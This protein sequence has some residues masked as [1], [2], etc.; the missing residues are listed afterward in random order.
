MRDQTQVAD[1]STTP[2]AVEHGRLSEFERRVLVCC[3]TGFTDVKLFEAQME[4][5]LR[6]KE[7]DKTN[8][9][10]LTTLDKPEDTNLILNWCKK[11]EYQYAVWLPNWK[12]VDVEGA[13]VK[14]NSYGAYNAL[15]KVWRDRDIAEAANEGI[16]FYD[17][18]SPN[19][20]DMNERMNDLKNSL[21]IVLVHIDEKEGS[22]NGRQSQSSRA[23][24]F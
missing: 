15:A 16:S 3:T 1:P 24:S 4:R 14:T 11:F 21:R 2:G 22:E 18:V 12:E 9:V 17:G 13:V 8:A 10:F 20:R 6:D 19:T 7:I 5:Y 23:S